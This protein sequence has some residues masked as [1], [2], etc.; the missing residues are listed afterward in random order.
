MV[1]SRVVRLGS[2]GVAALA[3]L[4]VGSVCQQ[5]AG[6]P[7]EAEQL[8]AR[9]WAAAEPGSPIR[10][11]DWRTGAPLPDALVLA[12]AAPAMG[13]HA[14]DQAAVRAAWL[15]A[16]AKGGLRVRL[17]AKAMGVLPPDHVAVVLHG[18]TFASGSGELLAPAPAI[19]VTLLC[20]DL[21]GEP[22]ADVEILGLRSDRQGLVHWRPG[23]Y[24]LALS[25]W[26]FVGVAGFPQWGMLPPDAAVLDLRDPGLGKTVVPVP[27]S[28]SGTLEVRGVHQGEAEE[29]GAVHVRWQ[30]PFEANLRYRSHEAH[31]AVVLTGLPIGVPMHVRRDHQ[32]E[33][34]KTLEPGRPGRLTLAVTKLEGRMRYRLVDGSGKVLLG[35]VH[36]P[37][38]RMLDEARPWLYVRRRD[39]PVVVRLHDK[40]GEEWSCAPFV[41]PAEPWQGTRDGGDLVLVPGSQ[42]VYCRGRI[43][44]AQGRPV[45]TRVHLGD[46]HAGWGAAV[47][48]A[49]GRFAICIGPWFEGPMTIVVPEYRQQVTRPVRRGEDDLRIE[50]GEKGNA[51]PA[52]TG[53]L[54]GLGAAPVLPH[55]EVE[56]CDA[57]SGKARA[58]SG[59]QSS[60]R[61]GFALPPGRYDVAVKLATGD[62]LLAATGIELRGTETV[63][64]AALQQPLPPT[65]RVATLRLVGPDGLPCPVHG[66][67]EPTTA[68]LQVIVPAAGGELVLQPILQR[69]TVRG[70]RDVVVDPVL[71]EVDVEGLP[72]GSGWYFGLAVGLPGAPGPWPVGQLEGGQGRMFVPRGIPLEAQL[73]ATR[74]DASGR[75][76]PAVFGPRP[77]LA[78]F[79]GAFE[80]AA[81]GPV[82]RV[83]FAAP[84]DL[85]RQLERLAA[86]GGVR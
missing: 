62:V 23:A 37:E 74:F 61:F 80:V 9:P 3:G 5:P 39:G 58:W 40:A 36:A 6:L 79:A 8:A 19:T 69:V 68:K 29:L 17:D 56:V 20:R 14:R 33:V 46:G 31:A 83:R 7:P 60:G 70:D 55:L 12:V 49:D 71:V 85:A 65:H 81:T 75:P 57:G 47:S 24:E 28:E 86:P 44:D 10:I 13:M 43:V 34:V 1:L 76:V 32:G 77:P 50:V 22:Q 73:H 26:Q 54:L 41:L 66:L 48:D 78:S 18:E 2:F 82:E 51:E 52:F 72:V 67:T 16:A 11:V 25:R 21:R 30:M 38:P 42:S 59:V 45:A 84:A 15:A 63:A 64:P 35:T 27:R 53:R 4:P